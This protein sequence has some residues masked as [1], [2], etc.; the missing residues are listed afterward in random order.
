M[1]VPLRITRIIWAAL[2]F[3]VLIYCLIAFMMGQRNAGVPFASEF[4]DPFAQII[5]AVAVV[6]FGVAFFMRG[7]MR[8]HGRP[9]HLYNIVTWALLESVTIY[10][11]VLAMIKFDWRLIAAPAML[12]VAG[13]VLTF[14]RD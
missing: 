6:T 2:L 11:L 3:A 4:H 13:F 12:T 9:A 7:W 1:A 5:Y 10:G 14:P 8:D